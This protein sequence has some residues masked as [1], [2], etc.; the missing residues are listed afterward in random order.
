MTEWLITMPCTGS[1]V[2]AAPGDGRVRHMMITHDLELYIM[3]LPDRL[4]RPVTADYSI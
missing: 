2:K 3:S 4:T 1:P